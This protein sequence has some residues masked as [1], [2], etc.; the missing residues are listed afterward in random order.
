MWSSCVPSREDC[1]QGLLHQAPSDAGKLRRRHS[2]VRRENA[3]GSERTR[4]LAR[5]AKL[6]L[7]HAWAHH[8]RSIGDGC[9]LAQRSSLR[10]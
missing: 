3:R 5:F 8:K 10:A 9:R 1:T 6:V 4:T 7:L 2:H